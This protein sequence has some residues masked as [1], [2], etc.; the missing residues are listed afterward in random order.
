MKRLTRP[1]GSSFYCT[2]CSLSET[3]LNDETCSTETC[4][5]LLRT[6]LAAY[7]DTGLSPEDVSQLSK[8]CKEIFPYIEPIKAILEA[9]R[10]GRIH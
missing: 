10:D 5:Q 1:G 4:R 8:A 3:C 6:R 9:V 2:D 7:E